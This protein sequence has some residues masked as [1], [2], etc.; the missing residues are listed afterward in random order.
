MT[1][2]IIPALD[3]NPHPL[4]R[5][6]EHDET[7]RGFAHPADT[8]VTHPV[9]WAHTGHVLD[10][11]QLGSCTGNAITQALATGPLFHVGYVPS[12][13]LAVKIY[14][15]A[16]R[17]DNVPGQYPPTDTGSSGIGAAKACQRLGLIHSYQHAFG[18]THAQAVIGHSPFIV[19][20]DWYEGMF[21]PDQQGFVHPTGQVAGGHEYLILGWDPA[22]DAWTALNSW[23][24]WGVGIPGIATT[25]LF[26]LHGVDFSQLLAAQ[27][28]ITVPVR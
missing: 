11:G 8:P 1:T 28:D 16:T 14:E 10:Q 7:S 18:I 26:H 9:M 6:V 21:T 13:D 24:T 12:E 5:H 22:Q 2:R 23:G 20:T 19:G 17:L 4:G 25:G 27:G 3:G 15:L